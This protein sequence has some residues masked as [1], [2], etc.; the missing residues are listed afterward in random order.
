MV[1]FNP[2]SETCEK[3]L[4]LCEER[5]ERA[6]IVVGLCWGFLAWG[7]AHQ[8]SYVHLLPEWQK[9]K[10]LP[11]ECLCLDKTGVL[12]TP[13]PPEGLTS[14]LMEHNALAVNFLVHH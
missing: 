3:L 8:A 1:S 5:E 7:G 4:P 10:H 6:A 12:P 14:V 13:F 2:H 11:S 9:L